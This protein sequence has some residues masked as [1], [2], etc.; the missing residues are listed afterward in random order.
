MIG[1]VSIPEGE[2]GPWKIK[3]F[4][5]RDNS[6]ESLRLAFSGR[7]CSPGTYTQLVHARR[8]V[9][10]SDTTAEQRDHWEFVHK[11]K[12]RV[13]INGLGIGMCLRAVLAKEGVEHVTVVEIDRDVIDLVWPHYEC[14]RASIVNASAFDYAP[15]KGVRFGSVWHDIWDDICEDNRPEMVRLHRKYGRFADWQGSWGRSTMDYHKS[16]EGWNIYRKRP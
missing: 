4:T 9:V 13:L 6:I 3:K 8:G 10:M 16:R 2:R 15:E 1:T 14:P 11:A 5:A 12:G 7:V